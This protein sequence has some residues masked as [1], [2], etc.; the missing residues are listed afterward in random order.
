MNQFNIKYWNIDHNKNTSKAS[1]KAVEETIGFSFPA[2][3]KQ[4][5]LQFKGKVYLNINNI[6]VSDEE[7]G[8]EEYSVVSLEDVDSALKSWEFIKDY[9][10]LDGIFP[11]GSTLGN[12]FWGLDLSKERLGQVYLIESDLTTT[13]VT[14]T[15]TEFLERIEFSNDIPIEF[16]VN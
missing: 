7:Y 12:S 16:S 10:E 6:V 13:L 9:I 4:F 3:Y 8:D 15:F 5:L 14:D 2:D 11:I 1:L